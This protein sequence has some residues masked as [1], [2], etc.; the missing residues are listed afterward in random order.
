METGWQ[1]QGMYAQPHAHMHLWRLLTDTRTYL[2]RLQHAGLQ[3]MYINKVSALK[4]NISSSAI[5]KA[6]SV[7]GL[8]RSQT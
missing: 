6:R 7:A 8:M 5:G 1:M 3:L 2:S 4:Y